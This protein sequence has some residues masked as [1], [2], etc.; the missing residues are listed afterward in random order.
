MSLIFP[1]SPNLYDSYSYQGKTWIWDG[2]K[3]TTIAVGSFSTKAYIASTPPNNPVDGQVWF[4]TSVNLLKT[5]NNGAFR[6]AGNGLI[7]VGSSAPS[8]PT[9]GTPWLDSETGD[10]YIY[11]SGQWLGVTGSP[12]TQASVTMSAPTNPTLGQMWFDTLNQ[13]LKVWN[14]TGWS[15]S[16]GGVS[17]GQ[18]SAIAPTGPLTGQIWY[19]TVAGQLKIYNGTSW[20]TTVPFTSSVSVGKAWAMTAVFGG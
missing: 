19:D 6:T 8:T 9:D 14:G 18:I 4:D 10:L 1:A 13:T 2:E 11:T 20:S 7:T 12:A 5:Y 16:L 3:W 17:T 15:A